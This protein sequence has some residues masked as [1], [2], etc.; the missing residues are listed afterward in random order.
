MKRSQVNEALTWARET[1]EKHNFKLPEF[2]YWNMDEWRANASRI[3]T[4]K[5][6][7]MGWDI[8]DYGLDDYRNCGGVL[9]TIRNGDQKDQS[10]GVPYAEKLIILEDGQCLPTHFHFS[11]TEDIINRFGGV[12]WLKLYNS[13]PD[14][15]IDY[16]TDVVVRIDGIEHTF[17]AGEEIH[18]Q[19]GCSITL[20]PFLYHT[21]GALKGAGDLVVGEVSSINDDSVDNRFNPELPRFS[22]IV[23]DQPPLLPLCN[24]YDRWMKK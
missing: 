6:V 10:I 23:E 17:K 3:D 5:K 15:S 4:I 16:D 18:I 1:L 22:D 8:T 7:M 21:F 19:P 2:A 11:K 14:E 12:L 20:D 24:E 9:F 13:N